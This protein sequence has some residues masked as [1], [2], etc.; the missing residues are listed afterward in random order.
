MTEASWISQQRKA[1]TGWCNGHLLERNFRINRFEDDLADGVI[2]WNLMEIISGKRLPRMESKTPKTRF[3][4][5]GNLNIVFKFLEQEKLYTVNIGSDDIHSGNTKL[6]LGLI[7]TLI[8]RY[9]IQ[10]GSYGM[11]SNERARGDFNLR[12]A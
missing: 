11:C 3:Q 1:F 8:L 10:K 7:W 6:I 5:L 4:K 2:L 9:Q 12:A